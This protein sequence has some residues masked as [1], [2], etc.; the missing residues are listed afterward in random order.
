MAGYAKQPR[1]E[2]FE[3]ETLSNKL[4]APS[5]IWFSLTGLCNNDCQW[6]YRGGSEI[7]EFLDT[8]FIFSAAKTFSSIGT[9]KCTIIGGEPT[10][11]KDFGLI[12]D[13]LTR[14]MDFSCT[15][16]TNGRMLAHKIPDSWKSNKKLHVVVSLHGADEDHYALNT[17]SHGFNKT[18]MSIK[19]LVAAG[20]NHSVNVVISKENAPRI[21]DFIKIVKELNA[22]LLCFTFA[23]PSMD[24]DGYQTDPFDLA[25]IVKKVH[26]LCEEYKQEHTFIFSLP[27]CLLGE[28]L[29]DHLI[30]DKQLIF[31]CP[32][33]KGR[34]VV[35]KED[36]SLALCTH[37]S[38][39]T[40]LSKQKLKENILDKDSFL[41]FWNTEEMDS[42]R[43]AI[44]V[45]RHEKCVK[46]K[47]RLFCKGGCPL[48]WSAYDFSGAIEKISN[49][50]GCIA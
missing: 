39:R 3:V 1:K 18:V 14:E 13:V 26:L 15:F 43:Q 45:H 35:I 21:I 24:D 32:I 46:C 41:R 47:Y 25:N 42:L 30:L 23:M 17:G 49:E 22:S 36:S 40:L 20:I 6:C 50:G 4:I 7:K 19:G 12:V 5:R 16:V 33:G 37:L 11:H 44:D 38:S 2:V 31:N 10:L 29:L 9:K 28:E 48:W 27:W 8:D 34:G